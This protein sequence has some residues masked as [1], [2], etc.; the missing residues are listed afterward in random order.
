MREGLRRGRW[1]RRLGGGAMAVVVL[2]LIV[3]PVGGQDATPG[4]TANPDRPGPDVPAP[5]EC[6]VEPRPIPIDVAPP[7]GEVTPAPAQPTPF[8]VPDGEPVDAATEAAVTATIRESVA[9][10][11]AGDFLRAY[12]LF[13]DAFVAGLLGPPDAIDPDL[14][15]RLSAPPT[16]VAEPE[17]LAMGSVTVVVRLP[18]GRVGALVMTQ[19]AQ[20]VYADFLYLVAPAADGGRWLIDDRVFVADT[21]VAT[22]TP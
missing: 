18:D 4:P 10:R 7:L 12:A 19:D 6:R 8:V 11:N 1:R 9:C 2:G 15:A 14:V 5:E 16:P 17:R 3:G 21:A 22:R 20:E 13:T